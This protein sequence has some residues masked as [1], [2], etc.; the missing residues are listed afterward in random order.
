MR[1]ETLEAIV[2][3]WGAN[4]EQGRTITERFQALNDV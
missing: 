4:E 3:E 1:G 2:R